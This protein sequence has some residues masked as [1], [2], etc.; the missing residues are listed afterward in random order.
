MTEFRQTLLGTCCVPWNADGTLAEDIF[1]DS[2]RFLLDRGL[3]NLYIFGGAGEGYAVTDSLFDRVLRVFCEE[4]ADRR[5]TPQVGII[6]L[7]FRTIMERI[8]LAATLG[9]KSFQ[10]TLPAW[11]RLN[12]QELFRFFREVCGQ[13]PSFQFLHYNISR[14]HRIVSPGEYIRLAEENPNLVA[15]KY[16]GDDLATIQG[17]LLKARRIQHFF[18]EFTFAY[19]CTIGRPGFIVSIASTNLRRAREY[20]DSGVSGDTRRLF[21]M[22]SELVGMMAELRTAVGATAHVEG[23]F[24]KL[25]CKVNNSRFPLRLLPPFEGATDAGFER[26]RESLRRNYPAWLDETAGQP[27]ASPTEGIEPAAQRAGGS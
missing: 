23:A 19:G 4:M 18:G 21:A 22:H 1:R 16:V 27:P 10:I 24:D 15:T 9:V 20:F 12:D 6:S 13:F 26:Y 8:E 3:T 5:A 17:L 2:I 14:A 25:F 7:S 11:G